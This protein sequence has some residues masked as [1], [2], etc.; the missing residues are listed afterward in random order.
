MITAEEFF[1]EWIR[2][3]EEGDLPQ[4]FEALAKST[5]AGTIESPMGFCCLG[6]ACEVAFRHGL[7]TK[8][9]IVTRDSHGDTMLQNLYDGGGSLLPPVIQE[10][11]SVGAAVTV[12][13][14]SKY[15]LAAE[16]YDLSTL[17]DVH[18]MSFAQIAAII[19][20]NFLGEKR[21]TQDA[22]A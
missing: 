19:A 12:A 21:G 20:W 9:T 8:K 4:T 18:K 14:P 5:T 22:S 17:N 15:R 16:S 10:L 13:V 1:R 6:V 2:D 11:L 3:L 7:V